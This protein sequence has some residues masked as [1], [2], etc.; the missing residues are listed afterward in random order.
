[1]KHQCSVKLIPAWGCKSGVEV[2]FIY[3]G[4]NCYVL[5][6]EQDIKIALLDR[7]CFDVWV[8]FAWRH[9]FPITLKKVIEAVEKYKR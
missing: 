9:Y 3:R 1:M 6:T 5:T 4:R 7:S 2:V 8:D